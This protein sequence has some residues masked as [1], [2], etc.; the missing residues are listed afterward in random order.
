MI[1][2]VCRPQ[3]SKPHPP[4]GLGFRHLCRAPV[5][6][7][8]LFRPAP[9]AE[10]HQRGPATVRRKG[11]RTRSWQFESLVIA[12]AGHSPQHYNL[13]MGFPIEVKVHRLWDF[14]PEERPKAPLTECKRRIFSALFLRCD[15]LRN[16]DQ[17]NTYNSVAALP[18]FTTS[19]QNTALD[20]FS[21][22]CP[23]LPLAPGVGAA[24]KN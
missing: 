23:R 18:H 13:R 20:A 16:P 17:N 22:D 3:D 15:L 4:V 5:S 10:P 1:S 24:G 2:F 14:P 12:S 11:N 19:A 6:M 7:V 9:L 21:A 8:P